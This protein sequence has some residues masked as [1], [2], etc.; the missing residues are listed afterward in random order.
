MKYLFDILTKQ[1]EAWELYAFITRIEYL[2]QVRLAHIY[3]AVSTP[4]WGENL[5]TIS[6]SRSVIFATTTKRDT[7]GLNGG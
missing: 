6:Q 3:V 4:E 1:L 7:L 2:P 5:P